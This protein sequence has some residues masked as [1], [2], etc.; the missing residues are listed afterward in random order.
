[1]KKIPHSHQDAF[2]MIE[3]LLVIIILGILAAMALPRLDRDIRQEAADNI[4]SAIRYTKHLALMDNKVSPEQSDWQKKWWGI[5]FTGGLHPYY[6]VCT[7]DNRNGALSKEECAIEPSTGKYLYNSSGVFA[8]RAPDES[9][10]IFIGD[11][12][13]INSI[14]FAGG[15]NGT[16]HIAFDHLGRPFVGITSAGNDYATYMSNDCTITF[17]FNSN[18]ISDLK[19]VIEKQTGHTYIVGQPNS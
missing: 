18:D 19:I 4:L 5:Y 9:P 14:S 3:L 7:D 12:Y 15:C 13:D 11:N 17:G 2:T 1:M 8:N 16:Q 6:K 10:S